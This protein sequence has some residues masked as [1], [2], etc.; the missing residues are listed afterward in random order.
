MIDMVLEIKDLNYDKF[1]DF[2]LVIEANKS[3]SIIGDINCGKDT[4]F[5]IITSYKEI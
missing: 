3:Y 1:E 5:K 2:N 4:L